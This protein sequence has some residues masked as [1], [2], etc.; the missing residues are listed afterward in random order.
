MIQVP[1]V[2][3]TFLAAVPQMEAADTARVQP[4]FSG[5]EALRRSRVHYD[6]RDDGSLWAVGAD[7]KIG[8]SHAGAEYIPS[9][10]S[11]QPRNE[12]LTLS[13]R[14]ITV[15]GLPL[16]SKD[17]MPPQRDAHR[18]T[19]ARGGFDER[20][21]L[22]P[23]A[24]EQSF[25]FHELPE[26][27]EIVVR[28][29]VDTQLAA[30]HD[31]A[32]LEF[33]G[34]LGRIT[35]SS[36]VAI[37]A[38]GRR[39]E[40]PTTLED[41]EIVIRVPAAFVSQADLPLVVD[42]V[43][44]TFTTWNTF[45]DMLAADAVWD[46]VSQVWVL[47]FQ[48]ANSATD[49]DVYVS[50]YTAGGAWQASAIVDV[51]PA[52][53]RNPRCASLPDAH[54][55]MVVAE[56]TTATPKRVVA[57]RYLL[58]SGIAPDLTVI[59]VAG[60]IAGD[61]TAPDVGGD[62]YPGSPAYFCVVFTHALPNLE[63][64]I[65]YRLVSIGGSLQGAG[66]TFLAHPAGT[67][68]TAPSISTSNDTAMWTIAWQRSDVISPALSGIWAAR[69]DWNGPLV[70]APFLVADS[71]LVESAPSVSS[72]LPG[73]SKV[74]VAYRQSATTS[75]QGDIALTALDAT[76][77]LSTINLTA[78]ESAG[79]QT[80]DQHTPTVETEGTYFMVLYHE[81]QAAAAHHDLYAA[82]VRMPATQ[83]ELY[84]GH[85]LVRNGAGDVAR[86]RIAGKL[87]SSGSDRFVAAYDVV[88]PPADHDVE[89]A[90]VNA[91]IPGSTAYFCSGDGTG[92]ACPCANSGGAFRGCAHSASTLGALLTQASGL[93]SV[94]SDSA[95]LR[96][97]DLPSGTACLFFQGT[98]Q[99]VALP[100]GDGLLCLGGPLTR[101]AVVFASGTTALCPLGVSVLGSVPAGG[102]MRTYQA[103]YRDASPTFCSASTFNLSNGLAIYWLP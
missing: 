13:P 19:F 8:F 62:P 33:A 96:A 98:T 67:V 56:E 26:R 50:K 78:L 25:A 52:S 57:R 39:S 11:N 102:A 20:Y 37:D 65:G 49:S 95:Q 61:V 6:E 45:Q 80:L 18:I 86:G 70:S 41:G 94:S 84:D 14:C 30:R 83:L 92:A 82:H 4:A 28:I 1:F 73:T 38:R 48:I 99:A 69:V 85:A 75:S 23:H 54:Q 10:G 103:W 66:P 93:P 79:T 16:A 101:L 40:A 87:G 31:A 24:L 42:P 77:V 43:V 72:P 29:Q 36:A 17:D 90:F 7:Y 71:G 88:F 58:T 46:P 47:V 76:T 68:E 89:A 97:A 9:F 53:W 12:V 55:F 81:F 32:G 44:T 51:S 21:D 100:F 59:D 2:L 5:L 63:S 15:A 27:G 35:Y 3:A 60:A 34:E 74:V 64:E 22:A 91:I